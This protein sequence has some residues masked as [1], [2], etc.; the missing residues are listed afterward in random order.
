MKIEK[1]KN[2]DRRFVKVM[3]GNRSSLNNFEYKIN[4]VNITDNWNQDKDHPKDV[5]G[6]SFSTEDKILR[7]VVRGDTIYEVTFPEDSQIIECEN[8]QGIFL[9]NKIIL[10]NPRII[11]DEMAMDLYK[12]QIYQKNHILKLWQGLLL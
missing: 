7:W 2:L 4:E 1:L 12:N 10:N 11:T 6:F 9:T 5:G 8:T 3:F